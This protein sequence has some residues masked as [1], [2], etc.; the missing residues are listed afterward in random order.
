MPTQKFLPT[1][2]LTAL[3]G[4]A[5]QNAHAVPLEE[6]VQLTL[7]ENPQVLQALSEANEVERNIRQ[8]QGGYLPQLNLSAAAGREHT[9]NATT[10]ANFGDDKGLWRKESRLTLTQMLFD[11]GRVASAVGQQQARFLAAQNR[12]SEVMQNTSFRAIQAYL[13][14]LRRQ[15][16][17][18]LAEK[19]VANHEKYFDKVGEQVE[20]GQASRADLKQTAGRLA[21]AQSTL[22]DFRR[23]L[24]DAQA[25]YEEIIG[26]APK[27]LVTPAFIEESELPKTQQDAV[28]LA[29]QENPFVLAQK[30]NVLA[31]EEAVDESY[32]TFFP[33]FDVEL[34][35][36]AGED[37]DGSLGRNNELLAL[38]RM[39][40]NLYA[41]GSDKARAQSLAARKSAQESELHNA[42][43]DIQ[44]QVI[45]AWNN[46]TNTKASL[47]YLGDYVV[48]SEQT[49]DAYIDQFDLGMR[50]QFD[51]LDSEIEAFNANVSLTNARF[52]YQTAKYRIRSLLGNLAEMFRTE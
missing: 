32:S 25:T 13:D 16:L 4:L 43:R 39:N 37:V 3:I 22:I 29:L 30:N 2:L 33:R 42:I 48:S 50:T 28:T 40:Y 19:N 15:D 35:A 49:R 26:Y 46:F 44:S 52:D 6:A 8:E 47:E 45:Q 23:Q 51:L 20:G 5:A 10:T 9:D 1:A 34:S 21:L 27:N 14:V 41:G 12:L 38:V 11:G 7:K 31:A 17:L 36:G 18:K 24:Q